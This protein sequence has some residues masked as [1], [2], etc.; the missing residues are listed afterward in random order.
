MTGVQEVFLASHEDM[1]IQSRIIGEEIERTNDTPVSMESF[2]VTRSAKRA[3]SQLPLA[4]ESEEDD[5]L[6][7][8]PFPVA[9]GTSSIHSPAGETIVTGDRLT[10]KHTWNEFNS[11]GT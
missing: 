10:E 2:P 11:A 1:K 5:S 9:Q 4:Q 6:S 3:R 7:R 8:N